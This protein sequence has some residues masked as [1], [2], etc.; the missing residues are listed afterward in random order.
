MFNNIGGK[1]KKI[2]KILCWI[3]IGF[4]VLFGILIMTAGNQMQLTVNG[5]YATAP[6]AL[7]GILFIII[8]S[9]ASWIGSLFAYGFGQLIENTDSIRSNT[10]K[11]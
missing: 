8:G 9:L 3:G 11:D 10:A 1:I 6:T 5:T 2:A 4:S 7:M